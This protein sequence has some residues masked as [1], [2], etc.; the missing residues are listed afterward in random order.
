MTASPR[1]GKRLK[2]ALSLGL[3][4][5]LALLAGFYV[6]NHLEEFRQLWSR[7]VPAGLWLSLA[8]VYCGA[9]VLSSEIIRLGINVQGLSLTF[10]EGLALSMSTMAANYFLPLKGG[11][12]LRALYCLT[13]YKMP[14]SDF[15]AQLLAVSVHTLAVSSLLGLGSILIINPPLGRD[16]LLLY[17]SLFFLAGLASLL[18][19][20]R[21]NLSRFPRLAN[22]AR[23]WDLFRARKNVLLKLTACQ[24]AY[25]LLL[26]LINQL[27]FKAYEVTLTLPQA[28]FYGVGQIHSTIINLT[29]AGLGI[30]ETFGVLA[31]QILGFSPAEALMAQ[32]LNRLMQLSLMILISL[33]GWPYLSRLKVQKTKGA[34]A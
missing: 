15:V 28:L 18:W 33:W 8:G 22:L 24:V 26:A 20:G 2:I 16:L 23:G 7:P 25:F 21:L 6:R 10:S 5:A 34:G 1:A 31:G 11:S 9:L 4:L 19:L 29:P 13:R 32:G 3:T 30:V 27:C 12:G 17:F 14:L